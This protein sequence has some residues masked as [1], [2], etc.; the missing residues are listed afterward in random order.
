MFFKILCKMAEMRAKCL[1]HLKHVKIK[2]YTNII[3]LWLQVSCVVLYNIN[4]LYHWY[5]NGFQLLLDDPIQTSKKHYTL[6]LMLHNDPNY[7]FRSFCFLFTSWKYDFYVSF[8]NLAN[9]LPPG[10]NARLGHALNHAHF[11]RAVGDH[12]L[13]LFRQLA[14]AVKF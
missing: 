3:N 12:A 5:D 2:T 4:L 6:T 10:H 11:L 7:M 9:L 1:E 13:L 8:Q 14:L